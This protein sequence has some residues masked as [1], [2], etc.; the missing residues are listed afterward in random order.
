LGNRGV[1]FNSVDRIL[2]LAQTEQK[3]RS[4]GQATMFNLFGQQT[5]VPMPGLELKGADVSVKEK[6]AWE[7]ELMG[8]YLSEHPL[9]RY[10]GNLN[11]QNIT[12]IGQIT[13]ELEGQNVSLVGMVTS[14][15]ELSTKD[16][17][18][19]CAAQIEDLEAGIEI[20]VW[21]NTYE[22]TREIWQEGNIL[23]IEGKV[24]TKE[25][26]IQ[27]TCDG[28]EIF[29]PATEPEQDEKDSISPGVMPKLNINGGKVSAE[30]GNG[31]KNG[32]STPSA[33]KTRKLILVLRETDNEQEDENKLN[34]INALLKETRGKDEVFLRIIVGEE[35]TPLK[36]NT[37]VDYTPDL[38]KRL[39]K[40]VP[41]ND[42]IIEEIPGS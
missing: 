42:Q 22:K 17:R 33:E 7:K 11:T 41:L 13:N 14:V 8:V 10:A 36:A 1:L 2:S 4:S 16:H 30:K 34:Q 28:V 15:R 20:M 29:S 18:A 21:P 19:F 26:R 31:G 24:K 40:F 6:L 9:A 5:Q 27:V 3:L 38:Q 35:V 39:S 25:D 23:R 32:K 37:Y 12:L